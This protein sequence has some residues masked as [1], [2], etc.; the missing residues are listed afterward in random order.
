MPFQHESLTSKIIAAA[1]EVHRELGP[2]F[3]EAISEFALT[4]E[5]QPQNQASRNI[6]P[7]QEVHAAILL[8]PLILSKG[9]SVPRKRA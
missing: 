6:S 8:I 4:L 7:P 5:L 1:I 9:I 3:L 2:E